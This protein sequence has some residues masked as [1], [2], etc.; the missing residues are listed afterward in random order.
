MRV[1]E[2]TDEAFRSELREWFLRNPAPE[3]LDAS[4]GLSH[5]YDA[6]AV[7]QQRDWQK[8]L[9]Q[10]GLSGVAWPPE[11]GGRGASPMQQLIFHEEHQRAGGRGGELFFVGVSHAGPTLIAYGT[12]AQRRRWLPGILNG[13]ILF[14]QCFSEPGAA[15]DLAAITTRA[16]VDG[17]H[18]VVTGEKRWSTRAQHADRCELLVRSDAGDRYGGL[19]YLMADLRTPGITIRPTRTVTGAAEF[20]EVFFDGARI[21][22]DS[23]VGEIGGGWAVATTTLMFERSTAFAAMIVGLQNLITRSAACCADDPVLAQQLSE[24]SDDVFAVRALLYRCVAEQQ[25]SGQPSPA[26]GALKLIATELNHRVRRFAALA[27]TDGVVGYLESFGLRIGGG[28]SEIQR[29]IRAERVL[30]LPREPRP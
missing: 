23:V 30:G 19:T 4:I 15:S 3:A 20:A 29:N 24:L 11:Y 1:L 14:A 7:A 17:D 12:D 25:A 16:V 26:S 27:G 6:E 21:P 28:T 8:R 10:A 22:L 5:D 18:L 2:L 13:D 9:A